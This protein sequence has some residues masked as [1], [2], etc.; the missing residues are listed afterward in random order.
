MINPNQ[1]PYQIVAELER[2][3]AEWTGAP[4]AVA[5]ESGS[6][7]IFL[8]LQWKRH[9]LMSE[10]LVKFKFP[11]IRIPKYTYPSVPCSVINSGFKVEWVDDKWNGEYALY[12]F[13]IW[14]SALR[15]RKGMYRGNGAMQCLSM[16]LK[17]RLAVGRGGMILLD[18][19]Q[20]YEWLK[21]ARFD[22]RSPVPLKDDTFT[23]LGWNM[24]M[25]PTN[26]ARAI[27]LFELIRDKDLPDLDFDEQG[28]SDLSQ[29][30]IYQQ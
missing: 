8:C 20:A 26:A 10:S 3:I 28:Y 13:S 6:A 2:R 27:Q 29:F 23:Q 21:K 14:D 24:Y 7:A 5:V 18:D 12:P 11:T 4:Y 16:H 19:K 15:F 9:L 22:G 30:K 17:K 25:E 1:N